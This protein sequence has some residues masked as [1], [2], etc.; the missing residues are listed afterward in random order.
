VR[1]HHP[2]A[3][4]NLKIGRTL[5]T[6]GAE[7]FWWLNNGITIIASDVVGDGDMLTITD[8]LIVNGLQTSYEVF[9]HFQRTQATQDDQR[10]ILVRVI[11]ITEPTSIDNII[12][13]TNSQTSIPT[14][15]LHATED[16]H[17]RIEVLLGSVDLCYDRRKNYYR[18]RGKTS[19]VIV[20][21]P[22]LAQA[23]AAIVLQKPD[24]ARG[25]PTTIAEAYYSKLFSEDF[26]EEIYSKSA[27]IMKV[28]DCHLDGCGLDRAFRSNLVFHVAMHAVCCALKSP[29]PR[30][31]TI[32]AL[33]IQKLT[34]TLLDSSLDIVR[35]EYTKLGGDDKVAKGKLFVEAVKLDLKQRFGRYPGIPEPPDRQKRK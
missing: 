32:A 26:P 23:L 29:S 25:R 33:D 7:D 27:M 2:D 8:A 21:I 4:V 1:D 17:R 20:T 30:R 14:I 31:K 6:P 3:K 16:I 5:D 9:Y 11:K 34:S 28:V 13:A 15:W 10:T 22:Y 12:N 18:N 24:E 35:K 19:E